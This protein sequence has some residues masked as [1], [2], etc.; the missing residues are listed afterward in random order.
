VSPRHPSGMEP[1]QRRRQARASELML[2]VA[3]RLLGEARLARSFPVEEGAL[4]DFAARLAP[5]LEPDEHIVLAAAL[6]ADLPRADFKVELDPPEPDAIGIGCRYG[7]HSDFGRLR[8]DGVLDEQGGSVGF[9]P[10]TPGSE[11]E[12]SPLEQEVMQRAVAER[13]EGGERPR[14]RGEEFRR[15]RAVAPQPGNVVQ[16]LAAELYGDGLIVRYTYDDPVDVGS[17]IPLHYY[18]LAGVEPPLDEL[19]AEAEAAG[20]NL[21]PGI[22]VRDDLGTRYVHAG[23]GRGGVQV[24]HGEAQF[25]PAV[26]DAATRLIV[27]SYAG[28]VEVDL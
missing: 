27:S 28:A 23:W 6:P 9:G 22:A 21:E 2:A 13:R 16:V 7:S 17:P 14:F 5:E 4:A 3:A 15:A 19:I 1:E 10:T 18:D 8:L 25:T 20:G 26:P 11:V 12:L 24:A